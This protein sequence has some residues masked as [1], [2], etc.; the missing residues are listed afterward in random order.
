MFKD[1]ARNA[2]K[3]ILLCAP[4]VLRWQKGTV[5]HNLVGTSGVGKPVKLEDGVG[6]KHKVWDR[7]SEPDK[8]TNVRDDSAGGQGAVRD[9]PRS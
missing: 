4:E 1:M 7:T 8:G 6:R 5:L 2:R 9:H 3:K